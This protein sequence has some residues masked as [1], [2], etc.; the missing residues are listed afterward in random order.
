MF[1]MNIYKYS[2]N[3]CQMLGTLSSVAVLLRIIILVFSLHLI[4]IIISKVINY[5][6]NLTK[7]HGRKLTIQKDKPQKQ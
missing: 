4:I 7:N 6:E 3:R 2:K 1:S 5:P